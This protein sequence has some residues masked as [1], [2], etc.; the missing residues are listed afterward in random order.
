MQD[1]EI[2]LDSFSFKYKIDKNYDIGQI[3]IIVWKPFFTFTKKQKEK[4][5]NTII[6]AEH[7][8]D[9]LKPLGVYIEWVYK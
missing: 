2:F 5:Q 7:C 4:F 1:L 9:L 3:T 8:L 6:I